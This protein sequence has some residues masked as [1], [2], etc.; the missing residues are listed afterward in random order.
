MALARTNLNA[1]R[2]AAGTEQPGSPIRRA[3]KLTT[4]RLCP[5]GR[6]PQCRGHTTWPPD[7]TGTTW[8][9]PGGTSNLE[10]VLW[11]VSSHPRTISSQYAV[12]RTVV[13]L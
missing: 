4:R 7:R 13:T 9:P 8:L 5:P 6:G 11:T 1:D 12:G 3:G 2:A 10:L